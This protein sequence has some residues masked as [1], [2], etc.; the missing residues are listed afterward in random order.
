MASAPEPA[1]P[2]LPYLTLR[3]MGTAA[4]AAG[5]A[6]GILFPLEYLRVQLQ[7]R[8]APVSARAAREVIRSLPRVSHIYRGVMVSI[9]RHFP[10]SASRMIVYETLR[11]ELG[12]SATSTPLP[13]L[14]AASAASGATGQLIASP[15]DRLK[16]GAIVAREGRITSWRR[17][18]NI[19]ASEGVS[20]LWRG[21][22]PNVSRAALTNVDIAVYDATKTALLKWGA[23]DSSLTHT[24]SALVSG[25]VSTIV[26]TP[27]DVVKSRIMSSPPGSK[28]IP[29][30]SLV[31]SM[32]KNEGFLSFYRGFMFI[33]LRL[34]PF[35]VIFYTTAEKLRL[36][37]GLE[38]F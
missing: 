9:A 14:V 36:L 4:A 32:W 18:A 12:L 31:Y 16:I 10:Y 27:A 37:V 28:Q 29:I 26:S 25:L 30:S 33:Y 7:V 17:A 11:D 8:T 6:D 24:A 35:A 13:V 5:I 21:A 38:S 20:G 15:F 23:D 19:V 34:T 3:K 1:V 22:L 2:P